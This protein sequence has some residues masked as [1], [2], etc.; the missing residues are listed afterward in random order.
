MKDSELKELFETPIFTGCLSDDRRTLPGKLI[1]KDSFYW[2]PLVSAFAGARLEEICQLT[3]SDIV[4]VDDT[5]C[6]RVSD[7]EDDQAAKTDAALRLIPLHPTLIKLGLVERRS[8]ER[9]VGKECVSTLRSR[10]SPS[11]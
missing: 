9:R 4:Q 7:E 10:W 11:H 5:W 1:L 8:E 2:V 6:I 3:L